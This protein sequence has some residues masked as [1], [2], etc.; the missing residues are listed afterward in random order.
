M[1]S[2][3]VLPTYN[4]KENIR[5]LIP[6]LEKVFKKIKNQDMHILVVD[7]KSPDN[8]ALEIKKFQKEY[9]NLHLIMGE[10]Q[11]LGI[12]YL[13]GF[14]H[15][16]DELKADIMMMMDADLQHPPELVPEFMKAIDEGY[17]FVIGSRYIK[18]GATPDWNLKR[19][20]ISRGGNFFARIIAGLYN[21]HDC[22]SGFRAI[23][24]SVFKKI[25][26]DNLNTRGYAF[27]STILYE[28]I[29]AGA[30]VKEIPLVFYERKHGESKLKT[31][32][33]LEFFLNAFRLRFKSSKKMIKFAIV[34]FSGVFVNM[35]F[36][37]FFTESYNLNYMVSSPIAVEISVIWNFLMN[38]FWTFKSSNTTSN[39]LMK[40]FKFHITAFTG[41]LINYLILIALTEQFGLYYMF[42]NLIGI[43]VAFIWNYLVN[44]KWT[45]REKG[46]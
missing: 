19:K 25:R 46:E 12:A 40:L 31:K 14:R 2:V 43:F 1:K 3:I 16:I 10:K 44:V 30:K 11:G 37:W 38:N 22:T 29:N 24:V 5:V 45:W 7:D 8:T 17:D 33:M 18:G 9:K 21:V 39:F 35:F 41:F 26:F 13:N 42:S 28:M 27:Q 34:G 23:R 6:E 32:D 15:A 36:L 4:E 20:I